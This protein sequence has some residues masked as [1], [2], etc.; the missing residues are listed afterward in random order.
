M[1]LWNHFGPPSLFFTVSPCDEV[2]FRMKLYATA[3]MHKLPSLDWSDEEC[4]ADWT[5]RSKL[6]TKY[7][8]AGAIEFQNFL[9]IFLEDCLGWDLKKK[10]KKGQWNAGKNDSIW[11]DS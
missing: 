3:E 5:L 7:P 2:S 4:L 10:E 1:S 11:G 9:Q 8:G 6:R